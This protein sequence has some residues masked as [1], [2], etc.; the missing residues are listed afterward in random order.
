[1]FIH[2]SVSSK[3]SSML[4][5]FY[6]QTQHSLRPPLAEI[7]LQ[8]HPDSSTIAARTA[9]KD[10]LST[11]V[12]NICYFCQKTGRYRL[13]PIEPVHGVLVDSTDDKIEN[14]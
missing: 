8:V 6:V 1:M 2:L 7:T 9:P 11:H 3:S 4:L 12:N 13:R 5:W 14:E 10:Y